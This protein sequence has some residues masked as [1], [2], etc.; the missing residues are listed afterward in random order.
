MTNQNTQNLEQAICDYLRWMKSREYKRSTTRRRYEK[1]LSELRVFVRSRDIAWDD[2]FTLDTL[3]AF[4]KDSSLT[5]VSGAVGGLSWYL[6]KQ[7]RIPQPLRK[8]NYQIDLPAIYEEYLRYHEKSRQA[9]YR[10][11]KHIRRVIAAFHDYLERAKITLP[12][13]SIE[14]VDTFLAEFNARFALATCRLYRSY[15]RGF[16]SYLYHER[17]IGNRDLA[18][19][20]VGAPVFAKS[21]PPQFLRPQELQRLFAS[22]QLSSPKHI[23]TYAMIYLAY[24]L[25]I[26]PREISLISLD[27]ISFSKREL[28]LKDRKSQNPIKLPLPE[29]TIKAIAV[30]LIGV[31]PNSKHRRLFLSLKVPYGPITPGVVGYYISKCMRKAGLPSSAYWLRHTY[32]QNLLEAGVSLYE[33]KEMLGHDS[34]ESTRKYLHIHTRLMREVLFDETL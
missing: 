27:D 20:V 34:I 7:S 3:K 24:T 26:R 8:P 33:I 14:Q 16:L 13:I 25:G 29:D 6:F 18:P 1:I 31:R 17:R 12:C 21:K 19:L 10:K 23:R 2:I 9:R 22:L 4:Q 28:N 32:A 11:I 30:Y 5:N 15:L